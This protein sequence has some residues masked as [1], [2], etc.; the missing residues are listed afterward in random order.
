MHTHTRTHTSVKCKKKR[1]KNDYKICPTQL[2]VQIMKVN[3]IECFYIFI[4]S[5]FSFSPV[6]EFVLLV[7]NVVGRI[8]VADCLRRCSLSKTPR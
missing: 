6:L 1:K 3:H 2:F 7:R 8:K 5:Y 4:Q